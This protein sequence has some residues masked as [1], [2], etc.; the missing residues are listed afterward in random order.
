MKI[1]I[2]RM[3]FCFV[4]AIFILSER[5]MNLFGWL[6]KIH[7]KHYL[8]LISIIF[9]IFVFK[10]KKNKIVLKKEFFD[11][12]FVSIGLYFISLVYQLING[13]F[14]SYSLEELYYFI[15]PLFFV[16][17][18]FN[19]D[20]NQKIEKYIDVI[21]YVGLFSFFV[22]RMGRGI[23]TIQNIIG[24]FDI[25]NLFVESVSLISESDLSVYFLILTVYYA[26]KN[27]KF[28]FI[29]ASIGTFLGYKRIA[30]L[31]LV[32][33]LILY[34]F[35]PKNKEVNKKIW[36]F[37]CL[38]FIISPF[39]VYFMCQDSFASW[40][41]AKF[42][43]DFNTF[44]MT[45]FDIINTVIDA[46]LK[47]YG[48]GTVTD[49]LEKRNVP[50]Q[51]NMHNDILRIFMECGLIGTILFTINFF[52]LGKKN[53]YSFFIMIFIFTELFVAHFLGPGS[54]SLWILAYL[55]IFEI[56]YKNLDISKE[57]K[58]FT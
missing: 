39:A 6:D 9:G 18:I 19:I 25:R 46:D 30:V 20:K 5:C 11:I 50:G 8:L 48:L 27:R 40:F 12:L 24:L 1:N 32:L 41:Y 55:V 47:N 45:R 57:K 3:W 31:F 35:L 53:Y 15:A 36:S 2:Y 49:F 10:N 43:I 28:K 4:I 58:C 56:N 23:L 38:V 33:F 51:T 13:E 34:K 16:F 37:V 54:V 21:L 17:I 22:T 14:K 42:K 52:K 29:L 26:F 7:L 44:T